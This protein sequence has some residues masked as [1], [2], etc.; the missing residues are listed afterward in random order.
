[1]TAW[2]MAM[3]RRIRTF[4]PTSCQ[5]RNGVAVSIPVVLDAETTKILGTVNISAGQTIGTI[6]TVATVTS[7]TQMNGQAISMGTGVRDAGTQ[8]VT[9]ATNDVVPASQSGVWTVQPG[10][11][12]NTTAWLANPALGQGKTLL[13]ATIAQGAA[14]TT[15][16]VAAQG[17]SNKIKV[18]S[19]A[20]TLSLAGTAKFTGTADLTGAFDIAASGGA[21]VVGQPASHLFETAANAALSIVTTLGAARGHLAYFVEA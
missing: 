19:Y 14:G 2:T 13:F 12:A 18:V 16:L 17:G 7:L 21:V 5:R 20:F 6:T 8:R 10:N 15:E 11:T 1:M 4:E 3:S 9:I